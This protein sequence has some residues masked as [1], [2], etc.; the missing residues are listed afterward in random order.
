[1]ETLVRQAGSPHS[2]EA[3]VFVHG[4]PGSSEDFDELVPHVGEFAR[5]LAPD[6]PGF[7]KTACDVCPAASAVEAAFRAMA[8]GELQA[9]LATTGPYPV[10]RVEDHRR[11]EAENRVVGGDFLAHGGHVAGIDRGSHLPA[12]DDE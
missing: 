9:Y 10:E 2:S 1:V 7:G 5:V 6:M 3:V 12:I 4:N 11:V 8:E